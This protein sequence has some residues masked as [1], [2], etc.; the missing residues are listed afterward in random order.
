MNNAIP[1]YLRLLHK[2]KLL[3]NHFGSNT[4]L[5]K[6][7]TSAYDKMEKYYNIIKTQNFA[8]S[9]T[10]CDPQFNFNVFQNLYQEANRNAH[11]ARIRKQFQNVFVKYEQ[12]ELGL[13]VAAAEAEAI[14]LQKATKSDHDSESDLFK[15]RGTTD[16]ETEHGKWMKQQPIKRDTDILRY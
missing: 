14:V 7:C 13:Q 3:R 16:F 9:A 1:Q 11:R 2:L 15:P 4:V 12:R 10:I 5:G 6:A 8:I